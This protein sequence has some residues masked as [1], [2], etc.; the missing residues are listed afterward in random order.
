MLRGLAFLVTLLCCYH[1]H[2]ADSLSCTGRFDKKGVKHGKWACRNSQHVVRTE[3]YRHG[4]LIGYTVFNDKGDI[5]ET[6]NRKGVV[7]KFNPC[8]C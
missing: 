3:Q 4:M 8:G 6:R 5:V 7:K 2:A 1:I